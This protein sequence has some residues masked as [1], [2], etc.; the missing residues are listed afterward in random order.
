MG[1]NKGNKLKASNKK[2][3]VVSSPKITFCQNV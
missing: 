1:Q 2:L 3:L